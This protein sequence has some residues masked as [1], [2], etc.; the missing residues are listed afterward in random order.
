[1]LSALTV[2]PLALLRK[3]LQFRSSAFIEAYSQIGGMALG[4]FAA[5]TMR[6]PTALVIGQTA[7]FGL[8]GAGALVAARDELTLTFSRSEV[9]P[10]LEF[11]GHVSGQSLV[12]YALYTVP[13]VLVS[14]I[15]GTQALGG[16]SRANLMVT[17]PVTH[18]WMGVTKTLYP[19]ISRA[20][21]DGERLRE[22]IEKVILKT[23]G[24]TWPLFA[25]AAGLAPLG[26]TVILGPA[27]ANVSTLL[28][29][30]LCFGAINLAYVISGNPLEVLGYQRVIWAFQ[31][32]WVA[33]LGI[34]MT[35]GAISGVSLPGLLWLVALVQLLI[36]LGKLWTLAKLSLI[37]LG[38]VLRGYSQAIMLSAVFFGVAAGIEHATSSFG[39]VGC[40]F[41]ELMALLASAAVVGWLLP[42][43]PLGSTVRS[44]FWAL[45]RRMHLGLPI[46]EVPAPARD[47]SSA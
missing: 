43:T 23:I 9:R 12:Y 40:L 16:Y 27:W 22:L 11:S 19:L 8:I 33:L 24:T 13:S 17:L 47:R 3:R 32:S 14:R 38:F 41:A 26:V 5:I 20:R 35:A 44:G 18:L 37:R 28:P 2:V 25:A 21:H 10:L 39:V 31:L 29:P 7:T 34:A 45:G 36:H 1:M 15:F 4:A 30:I 42:L 46:T 6:N